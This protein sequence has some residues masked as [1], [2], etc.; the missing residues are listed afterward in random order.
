VAAKQEIEHKFL[1]QREKL[2]PLPPGARLAQ[3]YLGFT[4]TVRV[5]TEEKAGGERQGY[6]TI[7]GDGLVGRDEWEY[8]I[9]FEDA[10]ALLK[11]AIASVVVKTRHLLPV[12]DAPELKWEVDIFEGDNAG[13]I[14]AEI[15]IPAF[16]HEFHRPDWLGEDV[17]RDRRYKNAALATN[18]FRA[19]VDG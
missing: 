12:E 2:P 7:K 3:G 1:V 10:E 14:V 5:R 8:P 13:L 9:P 17:T 6:L 18:P 4:P 16:G 15:E 11:L 19:W